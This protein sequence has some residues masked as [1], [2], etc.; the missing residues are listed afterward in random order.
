MSWGIDE[1][2]GW[3]NLKPSRL[4]TLTDFDEIFSMYKTY[5]NL[6]KGFLN[7]H[8]RLKQKFKK[9]P[10]LFSARAKHAKFGEGAE[11]NRS[12]A[13]V[14]DHRRCCPSANR[15]RKGLNRGGDSM[16]RLVRSGVE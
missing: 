9:R 3:G 13:P 15:G 1:Q 5:F 4:A 10:L 14:T 2:I 6:Q 12:L 7:F 16:T 8:Y 11:G